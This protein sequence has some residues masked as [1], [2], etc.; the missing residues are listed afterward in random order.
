MDMSSQLIDSQFT[1]NATSGI[2]VLGVGGGGSNAVNHMFNQGIVDV[3]FLICNTDAQ[4]LENSPILNKL[5][6]GWHL[7]EGRGAGNN[8]EKGKLAAQ[9]S[10]EEIKRIL[11]QETKMLFI[12]AGM[13]GGTGTGA[14]PV[15]ADIA[16]ELDILTVGIVT[17]PF[18]FEGRTRINQAIKGIEEMEKHVDSL[19]VVNNEKLRK[20]HGDLK[21]SEAF[22]KADDVLTV[23]AKGIAEIITVHG[24][25]NVDFADVNTV[26]RKSGVSIMGAATA[27][28]ENRGINAIKK[29]LNSPLLN[30]NDIKGAKN[31]LLNVTSGKEE[32]RLDE[33]GAITDYVQS[34]VQED[35]QIIWGNGKDESLGDEVRIV[36]I[37]TGFQKSSI[38]EIFANQAELESRSVITLEE[39]N[40]TISFDEPDFEVT[41]NPELEMKVREINPVQ[42]LPDEQWNE[43]RLLFPEEKDPQYK[44]VTE[45]TVKE[46]KDRLREFQEKNAAKR[47]TDKSE[48][49]AASKKSNW[50]QTTFDVLFNADEE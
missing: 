15:I 29:A 11:A 12:T 46:R 2:K 18:K 27:S 32:F 9:E 25:V 48:E 22:S 47:Q 37:A 34:L 44:E 35:V 10:R 21:V 49:P 40:G 8:P 5:H 24:H 20:M 30:S 13:G 41:N 14:A 36:I 26:M 38:H 45:R 33:L 6:I 39:K 1:S 17:M 7:T 50:I 28:G 19:L 3:D 42:Q 31:I 4:A 23:A 43:P 16:R